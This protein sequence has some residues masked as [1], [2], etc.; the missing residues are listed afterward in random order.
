M[1]DF[2]DLVRNELLE[3]FIEI[4]DFISL[5][6]LNLYEKIT[7]N[8]IIVLRTNFKKPRCEDKFLV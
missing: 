1:L 3:E 2:V 5:E 4:L 8:L 7:E 6:S